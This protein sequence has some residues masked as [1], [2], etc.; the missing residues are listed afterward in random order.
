MATKKN[1]PTHSAKFYP[2]EK[3]PVLPES[4]TIENVF[5]HAAEKKVGGVIVSS[6]YEPVAYLITQLLAVA[7]SSQAQQFGWQF[8][9]GQ[10]V[11]DFLNSD[12]TPALCVRVVNSDVDTGLLENC[13]D[14]VFQ[15]RQGGQPVGWFL[16]HETVDKTIHTAPPVFL[17]ENTPPHTN[18]DPDTG[19]C[20]FCPYKIKS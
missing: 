1:L 12:P 4:T 5:K 3:I 17:C 11:R 20:H 18:S 13:P 15:I 14:T 10:S 9:A 6:N 2:F 19:Y 16:N 7:S 8:V